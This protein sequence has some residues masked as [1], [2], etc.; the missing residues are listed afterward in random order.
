[1]GGRYGVRD[2]RDIKGLKY[3]DAFVTRW[4]FKQG[5]ERRPGRMVEL[6]S[7]TGNNLAL[8]L[9]YGWAVTGVDFSAEALADA[10]FNLGETASL[11]EADLSQGLPRLDDAPFDAVMI[12]NL[13]CY[14]RSAEAVA[15]LTSLETQLAP[16]AD[17]FLS[18]RLTDDHRYG[19]GVEVEPHTWRLSTEETGEAGL[20]NRFYDAGEL[21]ALLVRTLGL[22]DIV[23]LQARF[24]N[25]QAGVRVANSD[26]IVWG[27][28][29]A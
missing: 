4:F 20:I 13:L 7:G 10:R 17:V 8:P 2:L 3:P 28:A 27:K 23:A 9:A 15:V 21:E 26:L 29:R 19:K 16:G 22:F 12:P 5:L 6:G 25:V 24:E 18:T 11:V 1:M 14:L